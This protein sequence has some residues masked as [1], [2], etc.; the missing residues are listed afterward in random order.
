M[1]DSSRMVVRTVFGLVDARGTREFIPIFGVHPTTGKP[2]A[3]GSLEAL[4]QEHG[5]V[6]QKYWIEWMK[7][8]GILHRGHIVLTH[9][10]KIVIS[11]FLVF[12]LHKC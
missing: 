2:F 3:G 8:P 12:E 11:V 6:L 9:S 1:G 10:T 4:L 5:L 7:K